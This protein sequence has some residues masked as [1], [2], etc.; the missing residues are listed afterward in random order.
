MLLQDEDPK[1][2]MG[3]AHSLGDPAYGQAAMPLIQALN[4]SEPGV[5]SEAA[6]ALGRRGEGQAIEPLIGTLADPERQVRR[7]AVEALAA[8]GSPAVDPLTSALNESDNITEAGAA[9]ALGLIGEE[10]SAQP[11]IQAFG[12]GDHAVRQAMIAALVEINK[13]VAV[14][15]LIQILGDQSLKSDLRA[16]AAW[17]LGEMNDPRAKDPLIYAMSYDK[18]NSV[19]MSAAKAMKKVMRT[20]FDQ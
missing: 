3:A 11:L 4:D 13:S 6:A 15:P 14:S 2:R 8:I 1:R 9:A 10:S 20:I 7:D 17:A 16:D 18:E 5:R 19:R 12:N